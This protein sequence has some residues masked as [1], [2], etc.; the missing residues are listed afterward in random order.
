MNI[1]SAF[2]RTDPSRR[3]GESHSQFI[4]RVAGPFWDQVRD[5]IEDW[6]SRLCSDAQAD[7]RG[8]LRSRDDRQSKGAFFELYLHECLLRMGYTVTCHPEVDATSRR[9]DFLAEKDG[10]VVYVEARSASSSDVAVGA[11]AR[12]N[13]V[14]ES[15]D[16][17]NSPNFFLW[18]DVERQGD[19]PLRARPLRSTLEKWLRELNPDAYRDR[20]N[21]R[22]D[23]PGMPYEA[24]GWRIQFH[25]LPKSPEARGKE[26]VRPLGIFGGGR[27]FLVQDKEGIKNALNDKGSAYGPLGAPYVVA[28]ASS[29]ITTDDYDVKNALYGTEALLIGTGPGGETHSDALVR[30]PDGYWYKGDHW[31]HRHVSAVLVV[32][33]LHPAFVGTQQHTIWEHPD[34]EWS[35]PPLPMWRRSTVDAHGAM[36]FVDP[37]RTPTEWFGLTDPWPIGEPFP[38]EGRS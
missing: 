25:A 35:V 8:R 34:P 15:L 14:Y 12:V 31:G 21:G 2:E 29:S 13:T 24:D 11:A 1:F 23:F 19:G 10:S 6:F 9:P 37:A 18:I 36:H 5:L 33:N 28:V 26:G 3:H 7:V 30:N 27:A 16:K 32:K 38:R 20:G 22:H 17:T 4:D